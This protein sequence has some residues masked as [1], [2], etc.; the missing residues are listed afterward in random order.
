MCGNY[1]REGASKNSGDGLATTVGKLWPTLTVG[2]PG[3]GKLCGGSGHFNMLRNALG[4]EEAR[5][6]SAGSGGRLNP[7][8]VETLMGLP[9]GWTDLECNKLTELAGWPALM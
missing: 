6:L 9:I 5:K 4:V 7:D 1:N 2:T 3:G 8:W